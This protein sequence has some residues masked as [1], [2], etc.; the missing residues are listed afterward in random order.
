MRFGIIGVRDKGGA[1]SARTTP[2]VIMDVLAVTCLP[3]W[4]H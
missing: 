4:A 1:V 3:L 2:A